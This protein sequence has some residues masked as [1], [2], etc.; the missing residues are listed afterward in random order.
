MQM[1]SA[2]KSLLTHVAMVLLATG[3]L[4]GTLFGISM[5]AH[6]ADPILEQ[7]QAAI[8]RRLNGDTVI[9]SLACQGEI[10]CGIRMIPQAYRKRTYLPLWIDASL[11]LEKAE[12]MATAI[13]RAGEEGLSARA[14][15]LEAI[16][17]LLADICEQS[18]TAGS[19]SVPPELWADLDLILTDAFLLYG[20]HLA[21]GRVNPETLHTDW[22]INPGAV[23]L[24][25]A[26]DEAASTGRV[27]A[28][29]DN[30]RP[31][32]SGYTALRHAL[33]KLRS[34]AADRRWPSFDPGE[35]LRP[36][37]TH[38]TVDDLRQR[39]A[40][41][42]DASPAGSDAD[43]FFFD[44]TL[45]SAVRRFQ[46]R[47]GL[48]VDGI[49]GRE[50]LGM[51]NVPV[52]QRIRQVVLNLERWRWLPH[53]LAT[54]YIIVNTADFKLK[55]VENGRVALQMRVVVGRP[56]RRSPV[57][58]ADMTYLV[59]NPYWNVPTTIAVEDILPEIRKDVGYLAQRNIRVFQNWEVDAPEVDPAA[60][61][62]QAY[63]ADRFPFRLRQDPGPYNALGR[64]KFMFP[65]LFAVYLHDTPDRSLFNRVH[66]DFSSGCIRVESPAALADFVLAGDDRWTPEVLAGLIEKGET[67]T[68]RLK[69]PVP[70]HLLYMTAWT[71]E[72][73]VLQFRSDIYDRDK[74]LEA[75]L[76]RRRPNKLPDFVRPSR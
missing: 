45:E 15:H 19:A 39:L 72:T 31:T 55:A 66:R 50:T 70:V 63:H 21:A 16:H 3:V 33:H 35:T 37:D 10:I 76:N 11:N 23:D 74:A 9:E 6:G 69:Q 4:A 71:D 68:V 60:V 14:Y 59:I 65:N 57:F 34:L 20:S 51:L 49:A 30:L 52:S 27:D 43:P 29:L 26:L 41:S 38:V 28:T 73:G 8:E 56:A 48:K 36:G 42:G 46:E 54:R 1:T 61:D 5:Q 40:A 25:A 18:S 7:V 58:S 22:K 17:D 75:A 47:N 13:S 62:W 53:Y 67:R 32:H 12:A 24:L 2:K 44:A 64:I